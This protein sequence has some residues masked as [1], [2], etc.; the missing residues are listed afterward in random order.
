[1]ASLL[2]KGFWVLFRKQSKASKGFK[3]GIMPEIRVKNAARLHEVNTGEETK[4][5]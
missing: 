4:R 3:A 5:M 2:D 1:M